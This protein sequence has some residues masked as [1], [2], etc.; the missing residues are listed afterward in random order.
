MKMNKKTV[1]RTILCLCMMLILVLGAVSCNKNEKEGPAPGEVEVVRVTVAMKAGEQI[2]EDKVAVQYV[3]EASVPV[4][5]L[6]SLDA[7]VGKYLVT[8]VVV[9]DYIFKAKLSDSADVNDNI[10]GTRSYIAVASYVDLSEDCADGIQ[11]LI[12]QNPGRTLYFADGTYTI[13]KPLVI[14]AHPDEKVSFEL[15]DYAVIK[16]AD[17]WSSNDA[18]IRLGAKNAD[19]FHDEVGSTNASI[20]GGIID[21]NGKAKGIAVE[22]G[23]DS[24][25]TSV[26]VKNTTVGIV[27]GDY[28]GYRAK[29]VVENTDIVGNGKD[30]SIG[31]D[32]TSD[33]NY[34]DIVQ[35]DNC[36]TGVRISG[37][38]NSLRNTHVTYAGDSVF[39]IGFDDSGEQTNYDFCYSESYATG[40]YMAEGANGSTYTS[41][42]AFWTNGLAT[43]TAF[44]SEGKFNSVVRSCRADFVDTSA[45]AALLKVGESGGMGKLL[46]PIVKRVANIDDATY[47]SYLGTTN[48]VEVIE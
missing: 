34:L 27:L 16:A 14:S 8:D 32:M 47:K 48:V 31:I 23:R 36:G 30:D 2:T 17:S 18:M 9:G 5:A 28:F 6:R 38:G 37:N 42:Y 10:A 20:I 15:A 13:S 11:K 19:I 21:G 40:F 1:F 43:Q 3:D 46:Y 25:I 33:L 4:N 44:E 45:T 35:I 24:A 41:C 7:I 39:S 26:T 29:T 12:D 22:G